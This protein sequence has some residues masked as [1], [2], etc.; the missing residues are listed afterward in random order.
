MVSDINPSGSS[1]PYLLTNVNGKLFF[2][3]RDVAQGSELWTSDGT[4][5]GTQLVKDI[6]PGTADASASLL[7]ASGNNLYFA[8][9]DGTHGSELWISD[10][11][12]DGTR[13]VRDLNPGA[14]N[15]SPSSLTDVNGQLYFA[16]DDGTVGNELWSTDG[17]AAGTTIVQ[18]INP[19]GG[20]YPNYLTNVNGTLFFQG[21]DLDHGSE[22]WAAKPPA[23]TSP[24]YPLMALGSGAGGTPLVNV[25]RGDQP[26]LSFYGFDPGFQGGVD[27]AVGD[28]NGDGVG[29]IIVGA[30]AGGSSHVRIF[31]G[32]TGTQL[33]GP[34]GSFLAFPGSGGS[35]ADAT[36]SYYTAAFNGPIHVAAGDINGDGHADVIVAVGADGPP[37]VKIFSGADGSLLGS[38][39]AFVDPNHADPS[40]P[41]YFTSA[42]QGGV[43]VAAGDINADGLDDLIVGAGPGAGPHVKVFADGQASSTIRS[44]FAYDPGFNGGVNV[45]SGDL[46]GDGSDD[47]FTG[48]GPGSGPNV[49]AFSGTDGS[50]LAS[51]FAYNPG[52]RGGVHLAGGDYDGDGVFDLYTAPA[53]GT[54]ADVRRFNFNTGRPTTTTE[55]F[56]AFDPSFTGGASIAL[57]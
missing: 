5:A 40:D 31:S 3:A 43:N 33:P 26:M 14:A 53:G 32:A 42:F 1:F 8:T 47:I 56:F 38:F 49:K 46:N 55:D 12:T 36:S 21:T 17:T 7:T 2:I 37:Q 51:F 30:G 27:V 41:A 13:M 19:N 16:A 18:D 35:A 57:S 39:L 15:A 6:H 52:F 4:A 10:G 11:T 54:S 34:L 44:F 28:V 22:L 50:V 45:A 29:D 25:L 24:T 20:S 9:D 23:L 48:P